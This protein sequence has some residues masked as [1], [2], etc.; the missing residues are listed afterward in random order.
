M[1]KIYLDHIAATPLSS[2]AMKGMLPYLGSFFGNPQSRHSAGANPKKAIEA[3]REAVAALIGADT[4]EIIFTSSGSESNNLAIKGIL[5]AR[6]KTSARGSSGRGPASCAVQHIITSAIEHFSVAHPIKRLERE[7]YKVTWLPVDSKGRVDPLL[8]SRAICEETI[9]ISIMHANNEIG[10]IQPIQEIANLASAAGVLFHVDATAT[11]GVVPF[12][13]D[14]LG[15][16]LASFSAQQFY[17]PKGVGALYLR[18]GTRILPLIDGGIQ[19]GGRRAGTENVAAIVGM[20]IAAKES[21]ESIISINQK[22]SAMRDHLIHGLLQR[23]PLLHLT[24]DPT[25][26][27]PHIASFAVEYV[28]GEALIRALDKKGII[29]ASGSSCSADALK[30]SPTLTALGIPANVAQGG[31]VIS[32][33]RK[34]SEEEIDTV[35]DIFPETVQGLRETSP[36]YAELVGSTTSQNPQLILGE[37]AKSPDIQGQRPFWQPRRTYS[38]GE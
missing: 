11:V 13:I 1:Q 34:T 37:I 5:S 9:L 8:V 18:R 32:L 6:K 33:G 31:I 23:V 4:R 16:D 12:D 30:I 26:R 28:D 20:G 38:Y 25:N 19:E 15:M 27:L 24:G 21:Q 36:L 17:G 14:L 10:T 2:K 35:I 22:L 7:G 3:A 29:V